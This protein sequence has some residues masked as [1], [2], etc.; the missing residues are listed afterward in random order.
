MCNVLTKIIFV[1][2]IQKSAAKPE[3]LQKDATIVRG[4][5]KSDQKSETFNQLWTSE[6]QRK[7]EELL[8]KYPPERIEARRH[9]KIANELGNK[10]LQQV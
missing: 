9:R 3:K 1:E 8:I 10:T 7:L 4:R 2:L 5:V 6:E